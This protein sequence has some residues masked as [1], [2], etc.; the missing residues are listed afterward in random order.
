MKKLLLLTI[1]L[2]SFQTANAQTVLFPRFGGTGIGSATAADV[3]KC[4]K[5]LD[6]SPF[7]YE[8]GT[9]GSGGGG[10]GGG[11]FS[12][13]TSNVSGRLINYPNNTTDIVTI[14]ATATTSAEFYFD[15]NTLDAVINGTSTIRSAVFNSG[16][17]VDV[18]TCGAKGDGVTDDTAAINT[19]LSNLN[20][21]GGG[22][23]YISANYGRTATTKYRICNTPLNVYP[24][25]YVE[26]QKGVEIQVCNGNATSTVQFISNSGGTYFSTWDGG[27]FTEAG[28][29]QKLWMPFNL[30]SQNATGGVFWNTIK[31]VTIY[32]PKYCIRSAIVGSNNGW[33]NSNTYKD[34]VCNYPTQAFPMDDGG[35]KGLYGIS[36]TKFDNVQVQGNTSTESCWPNVK[37]NWTYIENPRC[38]D[39]PN[40]TSTSIVIDST[41]IGTTIVGGYGTEDN[42]T[43]NGTRTTIVG[44]ALYPFFASTSLSSVFVN[45]NSQMI[46]GTTTSLW[47][48]APLSI[49]NGSINLGQTNSSFN[50]SINLFWVSDNEWQKEYIKAATTTGGSPNSGNIIISAREGIFENIDSDNTSSSA[51]RTIRSN[52]SD[53]GTSSTGE[54]FKVCEP[55]VLTVSYASTTVLSNSQNTYLGTSAVAGTNYNL[56]LGTTT[57]MLQTN[58]G[59][60]ANVGNLLAYN[61]QNTLTPGFVSVVTAAMQT[62]A[63]AVFGNGNGPCFSTYEGSNITG[64]V[65]WADCAQYYNTASFIGASRLSFIANSSGVLTPWQYVTQTGNVTIGATSTDLSSSL[66]RLNVLNIQSSTQDIF[67]A[68]Q[69]TGTATSTVFV[70]KSTGFTGIA[71]SS[72]HQALTVNGN[73]YIAGFVTSTSTTAASTFPYASTTAL[74]GTTLCISTDCR[75]AWPSS[76][77]VGGSDTQVQFNDGGSALGGDAGFTY[78]KTDDRATVSNASTTALSVGGRTIAPTYDK[79]ITWAS[80]TPDAN[81]ASYN[82][83]TSSRVIW[84]PTLPIGLAT[85]GCQVTGGS[86]T[87]HVAIGT[88]LSTTTLPCTTTYTSVASTVTWTAGS[89]VFVAASSTAPSGVQDLVIT[90]AFYNQ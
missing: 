66:A 45:T 49:A 26:V 55:G 54:I 30:E 75:T 9:C 46:F 57:P 31:N 58:T 22:K 6:D 85:L 29:P 40:A 19:C 68:D 18:K 5:V 88:G 8:L 38:Y 33:L 36:S 76:S 13:T 82:T 65:M 20:T 12:T 74:S 1:F 59:S 52:R 39:L 15:P 51:C 21:A 47:S 27:L 79:S 4:L 23:L 32:F 25:T 3:A 10:S 56:Y 7:T 72:P 61:K 14:G 42:F 16:P 34:V 69:G 67:H 84:L 86:G 63:S 83:A 87:A 17:W 35:T 70:I 78:N 90:G 53:G 37:H 81:F 64:R 24:N 2:L 43:N 50:S 41:A 73:A 11:T 28:T 60:G 71:T 48:N 62:N 44:D 80:S 77:A 89:K